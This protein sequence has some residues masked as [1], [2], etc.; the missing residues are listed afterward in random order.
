MDKQDYVGAAEAFDTAFLLVPSIDEDH[1]PYRNIWYQTG[2][3]YAYFHSG[4]YQDVVDLA[5]NTLN[6]MAEPILE[7]SYVWRARAYIQLGYIDSAIA[8]LRQA[9]EAHPGFG[10][11]L[12]DLNSLGATP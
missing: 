6:N 1:R 11:A 10:P 12:D 3:Y 2:P 5:P 7:E 9:L 4:R 8:D